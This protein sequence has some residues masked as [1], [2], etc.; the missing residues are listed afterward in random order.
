MPEIQPTQ[1]PLH[2]HRPIRLR[3]TVCA[4]LCAFGT[5]WAVPLQAQTAAVGSSDQPSPLR[6][7]AVGGLRDGRYDA[8]V[9]LTMTPGSHTYWKMP[10]EAGVPPVFT[11]DGSDN[12]RQASVMFPVPSRITEE[13]LEAFGYTGEVVFPVAVVPNDAA[14]PST[15]HVDMTYAICNR[16]CLPGHSQATL[17]LQPRGSG[18]APE[19]VEAALTQ[20]PHREADLS[21]LKVSR[22]QTAAQPTWTL[23]WAGRMPVQDIFADAP[24]GFYFST[25]KTGSSSWT[26]TAEQSVT[27]GKTTKVPV[28][29]VVA[30]GTKSVET[31]RTF[32][33]APDGK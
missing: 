23:T 25:K 7:V 9:D 6:L 26:L 4:A 16:I 28:S 12:V 22:D 19:L 29:L 5:C 30:N 17:T 3:G 33:I 1:K 32:D 13:G 14:K 15:L 27:A 11:F 20:V 2:T 18:N 8:G 21:D 24:E 31:T 10:G